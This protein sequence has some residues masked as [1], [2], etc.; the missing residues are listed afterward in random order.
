MRL[1][2]WLCAFRSRPT[3]ISVLL[4]HPH[5]LSRAASLEFKAVPPPAAA[6]SA[7]EVV[8]LTHSNLFSTFHHSHY[9]IFSLVGPLFPIWPAMIVPKLIRIMR[10]TADTQRLG[11]SCWIQQRHVAPWRFSLCQ[12]NATFN[13]DSQGG[14][15][16]SDRVATASSPSAVQEEWGTMRMK[17]FMY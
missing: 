12:R 5:F 13:E 8:S 9:P 14:C 2:S 4:S 6:R 16:R 1:Y 10:I 3:P 11:L 17:L 15:G 7:K